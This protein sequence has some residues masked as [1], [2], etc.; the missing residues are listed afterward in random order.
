M[1]TPIYDALCRAMPG[2]SAP[3]EEE[4]VPAQGTEADGAADQSGD[5]ARAAAAGGA[6]G[7][8]STAHDGQDNGAV[9]RNGRA[10]SNGAT[11]DVRSSAGS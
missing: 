7:K 2:P 8:V 5:G 1:S 10:A 6:N 3:D 9:T 11:D 4:G